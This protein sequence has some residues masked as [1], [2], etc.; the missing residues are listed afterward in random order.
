ML[1][2]DYNI[3]VTQNDFYVKISPTLKIDISL[4]KNIF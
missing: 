3:F 1:Y 4:K 2:A